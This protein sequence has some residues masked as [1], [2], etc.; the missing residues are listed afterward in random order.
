MAGRRIRRIAS[1]VLALGLI[2]MLGEAAISAQPDCPPQALGEGQMS[3]CAYAEHLRAMWLGEAIA[4]WTGLTTEG[5]RQDAPFYTDADWGRD[6]DLDWKMVDVIDFVV[7]DPWLAD[8]DTDI[9]YVYLH[10]MTQGGAPLLS[11]AQIAEGWQAHINDWI[12]VSNARAR[13]LMEVGAL[14]PV[15]S[16][17]AINPDY[18]QIDA[19]L[20]TELFGALAPGMPAEALRLANLPILTTAGGYA[21]HA[22]QFYVLLYALAAQVD[23]ALPPRDQLLWLIGEARQY[24]PD[25][26]KAADIVDFV[27]ADYLANPDVDDWEAT[28]DRVYERYHRD[29]RENGFL[30]QDWTESSVN[31]ASGLIALLYGGGDF[32]R[33]VQIGALTG[34]DSDNGTATMGGLIGLLYGDEAL[35]AAFPD[36]VLSDRYQSHR[37][38]PTLPDYLPD[39]RRAE[40]TFTAMAERMLPLVDAAILQ[41]GGTV[42]G[43]LWTLPAPSSQPPLT[44]NPLEQIYRSS[45]NN[46]VRETGGAIE[47]SVEGEAAASRLAGIADGLEFNFSGQERPRRIPGVYE[48]DADAG[49]VVVSVVYDRVLNVQAIWLIEGSAGG[50][51]LRAEALID[52]VWGPLPEGTRLS[53]EPDAGIAYQSFTFILPEPLALSGVRV[54]IEAGGR[55]SEV[56]V[57]ELDAVLAG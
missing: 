2:V 19:Q 16:M 48:R 40:D 35:T 23:P 43:D 51:A 44:L 52:G 26:S 25:T 32:R 4:N 47:V 10:L 53:P 57:V 36:E 30:Y 54:R 34:W 20:T 38:R 22:A 21:A 18:L 7:Q 27:V 9:E 3:R 33:T 55:L 14:P 29:A 49:E 45:A 28:R 46:Q 13:G 11:A 17:G 56:S 1:C 6:Q 31:F 39:D 24:L 37:T 50:S 8:D 41:A 42:E 12:W 5:V 15:T